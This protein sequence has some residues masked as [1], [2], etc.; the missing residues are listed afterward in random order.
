MFST[1]EPSTLPMAMPLLPLRA[2]TTLVASSG[3]DVPPATMVRPIT[4]SLTPNVWATLVAP[5]TKMFEPTTR[6]ARPSTSNSNDFS[7]E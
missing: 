3:S 7:T 6:Q 1:L 2:A 4:A 5:S